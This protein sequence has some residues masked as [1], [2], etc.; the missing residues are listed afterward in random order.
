MN[1]S[2]F[3]DAAFESMPEYNADDVIRCLGEKGLDGRL[4][5]HAGME[6]LERTRCD[7]LVLP[8]LKG[9]FSDAALNAIIRFHASGGSLLVLGDLP[10]RDKWYPLR[11]MQSPLLRLT[12]A[13]HNLRFGDPDP[14]SCLTEK[15]E[16]VLG[17]LEDLENIRGRTMPCLRVT[18]FP[19]DRT[20][21]LLRMGDEVST[22]VVV[23]ERNHPDFFGARFAMV[24]FN[25]GEPRENVDGAFQRK[26]SWK[27]GLLDRTWKGID[28]LVLKL[29]KW[30]KPVDVHAAIQVRP[31]HR[32]GERS[33]RAAALFRNLSPE[34]LSV[35]CVQATHR[36][37]DTLLLEREDLSLEAGQIER[38]ELLAGETGFGIH[39]YDLR[40]TRGETRLAVSEV[41]R[42]LPA[43]AGEKP[44][45][46][47]ST[48]WSFQKPEI[49]APFK[50]FCRAL[51][52]RG[53][54]YIRAN[55]PWEDIEPEP[56]R[57]DWRIPDQLI[58][59]A[60][61]E[62]FL[63]QF[64][65]FP[66]T[67]GSGLSDGGV[68][69]WSLREPAID[70]HGNKGFFPSLW[71]PFYREHYFG[72]ID[73]FTQRYAESAALQ[74]F[75]LDFGNSDFPYGYNYYVNDTSLFD[76]S[77]HERAAFAK[78]LIQTRGMGLDQVSMLFGKK[79]SSTD[80]IPVPFKEQ[81]EPYRVYLQF[82][83][84]S[85]KDGIQH[86]WKICENNAPGKIPP[87]LPGHGMG[88]I[89]DLSAAWHEV[90][91]R[92]W[93][94]EKKFDS[95]Y[96]YLHNSGKEWG[97]E[98]WQVGASFHEYD[99]AL[100]NSVLFNASYNSIPGPD[101][102]VFGEDISRI[103]MI[104][105]TIMGA[106]RKHPEIAI[107]DSTDWNAFHSLAH[108]GIRMDEG[109]DV[110]CSQHRFDFSCYKLVVLPS[111]QTSGGTVTGG[112]GM[113]TLPEDEHWFWLLRESVEKGLNLLLFPGT[114]NTPSSALLKN[115][116]REVLELEQVEFGERRSHEIAF[117]ET[118]G[119]GVAQGC[120]RDVRSEGESLITSS[121][122]T[123]IL[124]RRALG[125]GSL[126][127]AGWDSQ[128]DSLNGPIHYEETSTI[129]NHMLFR[130]ARFLKIEAREVRTGQT[131]VLKGLLHRNNKDYFVAFSHLTEP[132]T[133]R[134][135]LK[136]S[137]PAERGLDLST[138]E[139]FRLTA[140]PDGW[141]TFDLP[142][143]CREGRYLS[144]HD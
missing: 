88:S 80:E 105:R 82:R 86:V 30:L 117:P 26:W 19:P 1:I 22:A 101:L 58:E 71:S 32:V 91:A 90:K 139:T 15:G 129:A 76:Y 83:T 16:E 28:S 36:E 65:M 106:Q 72:M 144:F 75:V 96:T 89:A 67:R 20:W 52:D 42:I 33:S 48:Y 38:I 34:S 53:A 81:E 66:T 92:H 17:G 78:Y 93:N 135:E 54:Q 122:G 8:Y 14:C 61:K 39:T 97:G 77:E 109:A 87:D 68:P 59:F 49:S 21:P 103:G 113:P 55:I 136:L 6:A 142:L 132:V 115:W 70:R 127:L 47:F 9:N 124:V 100:F 141:Y 64:W 74:R 110:L 45:Y 11:N 84:W 5:S 143:H 133:P 120:C 99:D 27:P 116:L 37:S 137:R 41:E 108:V 125:K 119:G 112:G 118:F 40:L 98:A 56:G 111:E 2:V 60:E 35:D 18:A 138:G 140:E 130:M 128:P 44:G 51:L 46:G 102:G 43:D 123:H 29:I 104:R 25:G 4:V 12:R 79:I 121:D 85:L 73:A 126:L 50:G 69:W 3:R 131:H 24:G 7:I 107:L 31:V 10:H 134:I 63:L 114:M 23:V 94:E 57:Y 13:Y 62:R 95:K